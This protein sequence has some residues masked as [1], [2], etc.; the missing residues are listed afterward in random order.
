MS[1]NSCVDW[2]SDALHTV[3]GVASVEVSL[4]DQSAVVFLLISNLSLNAH[5][6]LRSR[7]CSQSLSEAYS[8]S[9][10]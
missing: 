10:S 1:C 2:V 6:F 4:A 9:Y 5:L 7:S 8:Y 3:P